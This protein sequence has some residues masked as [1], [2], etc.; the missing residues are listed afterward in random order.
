MTDAKRLAQG[1]NNYGASSHVCYM[2]SVLL[3]TVGLES[4][5]EYLRRTHSPPEIPEWEEQGELEQAAMAI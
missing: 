2:A 1:L 3:A 4:A 5:L